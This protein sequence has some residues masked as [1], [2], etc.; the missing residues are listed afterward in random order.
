MRH[1]IAVLLENE[2]GALSRVVGLFAQRN[3]NIESL[4]VARTE[5]PTLSRLTLTTDKGTATVAGTLFGDQRPRVVEV[6][7]VTIEFYPEGRLLVLRNRDVP[8]VVGRIGS[9]LGRRGVNIAGI[10]LGRANS[11][12]AVSL[13]NIDGNV[14]ADT[15]DEIR[16]I[17]EIVLVRALRV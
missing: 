1:I 16:K 13:L 12:N 9:I 3:Y 17:D 15:L 2:A 8:G 14:S 4:T 7:G 6:D 5:D 11:D 10:H